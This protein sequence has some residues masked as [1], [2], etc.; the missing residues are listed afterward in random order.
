[1][2]SL[3][4][5]VWNNADIYIGIIDR[6]KEEMT[7]ILSIGVGKTAIIS[8]FHGR[9]FIEKAASTIGV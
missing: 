9:E 6:F 3:G 1:M 8:L 5:K 7:N 2:S 4:V